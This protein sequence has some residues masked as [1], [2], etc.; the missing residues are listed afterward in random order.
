VFPDLL[1]GDDLGRQVGAVVTRRQGLLVLVGQ[2]EEQQE[3][4]HRSAVEDVPC[5][6]GGK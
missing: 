2:G 3:E 5:R 4:K 1:A 6:R